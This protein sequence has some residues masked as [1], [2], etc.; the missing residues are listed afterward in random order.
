M[1]QAVVLTAIDNTT[2]RLTTADAAMHVWA[3]AS[4]AENRA[5]I[6]ARFAD[7]A[8]QKQWRRDHETLHA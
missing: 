8:I 5:A 7:H 1:L 6:P 2:P 4:T 3:G